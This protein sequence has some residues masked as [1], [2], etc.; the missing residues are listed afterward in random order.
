MAET[1]TET[2]R[3]V[4]QATR[5]GVRF[6]PVQIARD[7]YQKMIPL[8][9]ATSQPD[10]AEAMVVRR[11]MDFLKGH[12]DVV[13][14]KA[15]PTM[16]QAVKQNS[17]GA[18]RRYYAKLQPNAKLKPRDL[19]FRL[20]FDKALADRLRPELETISGVAE[21]NSRYSSLAEVEG[22]LFPASRDMEGKLA[23][24][25]VRHGSGAMIGGLAGAP[26]GAAPIGAMVG[27]VA[28]SPIG[29]SHLSLIFNNPMLLEAI[30]RSPNLGSAAMAG[31][32]A[33]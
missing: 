4:N 2:K 18:L 12:S 32:Q 6:D 21:Q 15:T 5:Q 16:M 14:G 10:A 23:E 20:Q 33:P 22:R 30:R 1:A 19:P 31:A 11:T 25:A 9:R 13:D 3:L 24:M 17:D 26:V 7:V 29:L 8:A 28:A 27:S